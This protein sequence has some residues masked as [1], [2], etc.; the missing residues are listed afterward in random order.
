MPDQKASPWV[1]SRT[2]R[3][4]D[5]CLVLVASPIL[6]I[7][8]VFLSLLIFCVDH[9]VP[10]FHQMRVGKNGV[11]FKLYKLNTMGNYRSYE[12][13][14]GSQD[15]RATPL[16]RW[17][18]WM[19]LDEVPQIFINVLLGDLALVGPRPLL[20]ADVDLM[21]CRLPERDFLEWYRVYRTLKPGWTGKFG[22]SSRRFR[23][24]SDPYLQARY[25]HDLDYY[26]S[27]SLWL[28]LRIIAR[29]AILPFID[30]NKGKS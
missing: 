17:L 28:D 10:L 27:A 16:G 4:V 21:R 8:I 18:R 19:I 7:L 29:H 12:V 9:T 11:P 5:I 2:K 1:N 15:T 13:S 3:V 30:V 20:Q 25:Y 6:V 24:Q 14:R 22:V 23:I 26:R